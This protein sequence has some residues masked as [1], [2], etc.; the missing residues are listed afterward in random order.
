MKETS[1]II[2]SKN[3]AASTLSMECFHKAF[4]FLQIYVGTAN[5]D[6]FINVF[7]MVK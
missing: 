7:M 3:K 6:F 5:T 1:E 2:L 4:F